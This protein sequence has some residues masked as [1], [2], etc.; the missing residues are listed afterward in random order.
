MDTKILEIPKVDNITI[1]TLANTNEEVSTSFMKKINDNKF[2]I[3]LLIL[4]GVG[5]YYGYN[6]YCKYYNKTSLLNFRNTKDINSDK[7][8]NTKT[9]INEKNL[10]DNEEELFKVINNMDTVKINKQLPN[11]NVSFN[12]NVTTKEVVED[13]ENPETTENSEIYNNLSKKSNNEYLQT[14]IDINN[15]QAE[16]LDDTIDES[17][18]V[19]QHNLSSSELENINM[20]L[21]LIQEQQEKHKLL[22]QQQLLQE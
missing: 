21:K 13:S 6:Y 20:K 11:K 12:N 1:P 2:Y 17:N 19:S 8:I 18:I 10:R 16:L 9:I 14:N 22:Q 4:L 5:G 3:L 7:N 15:L